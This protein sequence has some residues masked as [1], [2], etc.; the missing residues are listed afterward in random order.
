MS[1]PTIES[2]ARVKPSTEPQ[3]LGTCRCVCP[4]CKSGR[5]CGQRVNNC[6]YVR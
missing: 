3:A 6:G 1:A 5:H 4:D 2:P